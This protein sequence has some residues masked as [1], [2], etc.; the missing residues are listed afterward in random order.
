MG[1]VYKAYD[2]TL[3]RTVA[4]K[5]LA[6]HLLNHDEAKERF[7][8]EARAAAALQHPN[9][10]P[11]FE[12]DTADGKP[13]LA[14]AFLKG[15][16]L[17][18]LIAK[19]P[20]APSEALD[21]SRQV[22]D[23]LRAAHAE[24]ILH[25]DIK[26]DNI[27]VSPDGRATIMDF[28]LAR[29]SEA[30]RL[31]RPDQTVGT[32][33]YMSPEQVLGS[34]ADARSDL[35]ALGVTLHQMLSA[36]VP[37]AG[38][39]ITEVLYSIVNE[40]PAALPDE[41]PSEIQGIVTKLLAKEPGGRFQSASELL[42]ALDALQARESAPPAASSTPDNRR[43]SMALLAVAVVLAA[44]SFLM[45]TRSSNEAEPLTSAEPTPLTSLAG[46][47]ERPAFSPDGG[48]LAFSWN[49]PGL[50]NYDIYVQHRDSGSPERI[51]DDP[52][53]ESSPAWSPDGRSIAFLR[54]TGDT[55]SELRVST[56]PGGPERLI[57]TL[58]AAARH[59]LSWSPDGRY[60]VAP[61]VA[62]ETSRAV[63]VLVDVQS[64][65]KRVLVE[66]PAGAVEARFPA[67]SPDGS[68]VAFET[69]TG[70][71]LG[72]AYLVPASGGTPQTLNSTP[73]YP[74]GL[75]WLSGSSAVIYSRS[76]P[77]ARRSLW[78]ASLDGDVRELEIGES[79][80]EPSI[81]ADGT[82]L[83][84]SQRTSQYD[85][86]R[87][88]LTGDDQRARPFISSTRFDGNPQYSPDGTRI[89]FSSSRSGAVEIWVCDVDGA[90]ARQI[91]FSG[92][93][94]SPH[95]SPDSAFVAY[96][97]TVD[98]NSEILVVDASG[99]E[100]VRVTAD[101]A[102][103][104]VPTWSRDGQWV[105][106]ASDRT[107][108][109]QLWKAP[110]DGKSDPVSVTEG[111]G[112]YGTESPDGEFLYYASARSKESAIWRMSIA[113]GAAEPVVEGVSSGWANWSIGSDGIYYVD[114]AIGEDGLERWAVYI[115]RFGADES[116]ELAPLADSPTWGAPG[117]SVAPDGKSALAGQ[118]I[119]ESDL[120]IV[121]G[122]F[123]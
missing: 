10:C 13:F 64:G 24:G 109:P 73:G 117:F 18:D 65:E 47:E 101:P 50:D 25:R 3:E 48:H 96:D 59:G 16:T 6:A 49:G 91:T 62:S 123:R 77:E 83:A 54:E 93:A 105:Y 27:V 38:G 97:S 26:P 14:M 39:H 69:I 40:D 60:I 9:I 66:A 43:T 89:L 52:A 121:E 80:S 82:R 76:S 11:V 103:D 28:G 61:D 4:L 20:L 41:I 100:P 12:I 57:T 32:A 110:V 118:V 85:V 53:W 36:S 75:T 106:F 102:S 104:Y 95:W 68:S 114:D 44:G 31:S 112:L 84:F 21:L 7:L 70:P 99:G 56:I 37:F 81:S 63:I 19:G 108:A 116:E 90:N 67:Y 55:E 119:V 30:T 107:G 78:Y 87:V 34:D 113:T 74:E 111:V 94:G 92:G 42:Q 45:M 8:R 1:V 15:E 35:W 79:A 115:R 17:E 23:G 46:R 29:L 22:A 122:N 86:V 72:A 98:G 71:W 5:F 51:T 58:R 120:M 88:S 33:A 2:I